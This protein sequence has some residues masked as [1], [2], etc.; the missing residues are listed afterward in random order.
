MRTVYRFFLRLY[1][2]DFR[3]LFAGEMQRTFEIA[4]DEGRASGVRECLGLV[5]GAFAEWRAKVTTDIAIRGRV[6]PDRLLM[7]P[8]GV[9]WEVHYAGGFPAEL[10]EAERR[11][12][13]LVSCIVQAIAHH[14]WQDARRFDIE[15]RK[16]R[17]N[18]GVLRRKYNIAE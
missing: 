8:P 4:C 3:A 12:E 5:T 9:S 16:A 17:E 13:F 14:R 10:V 11:T 2:R 6:L 7:R 18:L 1:P 15:E